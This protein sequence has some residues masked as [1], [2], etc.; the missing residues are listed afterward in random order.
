MSLSSHSTSAKFQRSGSVD[1]FRDLSSPAVQSKP[2]V[3]SPQPKSAPSTPPPQQLFGH[4][5]TEWLEKTVFPVLLPGLEA[6]QKEAVKQGC[7]K[8]KETA[9]NPCDFLTSWLYNQ[10]PRRQGQKPVQW[11]DIPFVKEWLSMH[12]RPPIPLFLQLSEA[13]AAL[14]IQSFWRGYKVRAQPDVQ[15]L[16]LWQKE[17]RENQDIVKTVE[18]FWAQQESRVGSSMT[19]LP[20]SPQLENS[21]FSIQVVSPTPQSTVV[22]TPT[23]QMAPGE[24]LTPSLGGL[25]DIGSAA[26]MAKFMSVPDSSVKS[27]AAISPSLVGSHSPNETI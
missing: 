6:L 3:L 4:P 27:L 13:Q 5:C 10:N 12:P 9:F 14:I 8:R 22:H 1:P 11:C 2:N 16:R 20:E 24:W 21:D 7:L 17:L 18:K 26:L 19:D 23:I 15:E 25:A